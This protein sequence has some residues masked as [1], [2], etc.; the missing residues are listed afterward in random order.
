[1][2]IFGGYTQGGGHTPLGALHGMGADQVISLGV[3]TA[4]GKYLTASASENS[5]LFWAIRGGGGST[6][7]V[8]T[9]MV[10]KAYPDQMTSV[11]TVD[12]SIQD[13]KI[14]PDT[15][16][17]GVASYFGSFEH[18][19]SN[20]V[21]AQFNFYPEYSLAGIAGGQPRLSISPIIGIGKSPSE[22]KGL[23]DDFLHDLTALGINATT[24]WEQFPSY[25]PAFFSQL[26]HTD[27]TIMP[28]NMNY[29]SRLIPRA[30]FDKKGN[31]L[32]ATVAAYRALVEGGH[33][34]NG[35]QLSPTLEKGKPVG[36]SN[37]VLPAW[38][39]ALSHTIAFFFW[40]PNATAA[41]QLE[42]RKQ[43]ST[44]PSGLKLLRD[45]T[46]GSGSYMSEAD[47]LEPDFQKAFYG[48]NYPRLLE[49]KQKYDP[50][51]VFYAVTAVGSERWAV[52][53]ADGLP[54][55]DGPLCRV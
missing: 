55:E 17:K 13:S 15:F 10:V 47:R 24:T 31:L 42:I 54:T 38:R 28:T 4:D 16:W 21:F 5:D 36:G 39:D 49:I 18:L 51:D 6:F 30:N 7:G 9:S 50:L 43:F 53:T 33:S 52:K 1:M 2:G 32:N 34:I 35:F 3:V 19:T 8:V 27:T 25:Y 12:F 41:E 44:G 40:P 20:G 26:G 11:G 37:A 46:P 45:I 48:E 29:G 14:S 22:L 23:A